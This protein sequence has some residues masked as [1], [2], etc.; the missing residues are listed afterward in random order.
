MRATPTRSG[1]DHPLAGGVG[2]RSDRA[3]KE[4]ADHAAST[5]ES[6]G[7]R[8]GLAQSSK[9]FDEPGDGRE[10][11]SLMRTSDLMAPEGYLDAFFDTGSERQSH[12]DAPVEK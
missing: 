9:L 7:A 11:F 12:L 3:E 1:A 5:E 2:R 8:L 4:A 10:I 6:P